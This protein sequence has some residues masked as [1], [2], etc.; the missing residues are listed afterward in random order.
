MG[1]CIALNFER[2]AMAIINVSHQVN[3]FLEF[4]TIK[5]YIFYNHS[6]YSIKHISKLQCILQSS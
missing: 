3:D 1:W 4:L 6:T 5:I 2:S